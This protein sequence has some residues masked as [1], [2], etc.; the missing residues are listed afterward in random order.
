MPGVDFSEG[1]WYNINMDDYIFEWDENKNQHNITY[2]KINFKEA[3]T[4][5]KDDLAI[6]EYDE[7]H[8]DYEERFHIT[9]Y[10]QAGRMLMVCFCERQGNVIRL[11]SAR[12]AEK[13]EIRKY[14]IENGLI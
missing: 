6:I 12:K 10:S 2:H 8:S 13:H 11:I 5:F 4:V 3:K 1:M 9:G 7:D 14:E